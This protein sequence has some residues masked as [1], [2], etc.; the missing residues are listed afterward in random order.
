MVLDSAV[1]RNFCVHPTVTWRRR[2]RGLRGRVHRGCRFW[3]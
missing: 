2:V 1:F 3:S